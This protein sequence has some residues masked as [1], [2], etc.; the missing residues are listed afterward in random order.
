MFLFVYIFTCFYFYLSIL[1]FIFVYLL[2]LRTAGHQSN[3]YLAS[4]PLSVAFIEFSVALPFIECIAFLSTY[5]V[6]HTVMHTKMA[7]Y[8]CA[9]EAF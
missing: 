7:F 3:L 1:Y 8:K 9:I 2:T 5:S 6:L 4:L